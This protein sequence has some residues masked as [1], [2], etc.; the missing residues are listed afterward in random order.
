MTTDLS[1][2]TFTLEGT[3]RMGRPVPS[4]TFSC[5]PI[6]QGEILA[7]AMVKLDNDDLKKLLEISAFIRESLIEEDIERFNNLITGK[8]FIV[9]LKTLGAVVSQLISEYGQ[10]PTK[11][12]STSQ[13]GQ[14]P[15]PP[16]SM[17]AGTS[18]VSSTPGSSPLI[19]G[20]TPSTPLSLMTQEL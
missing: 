16:T 19:D 3:D 1:L 18:P 12:S 9:E 6:M 15:T 8:D 13:D 4:Q 20:S 5:Y 10:R 14:M 2:K 11:A 17:D 7:Q